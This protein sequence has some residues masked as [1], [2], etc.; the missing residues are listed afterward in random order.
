LP[1]AIF[2]ILTV[3]AA[4]F[5]KP[6]PAAGRLAFMALLAVSPGAIEY[7]Q[8]AR[9]YSLL[10]L[11][12]TVVTSACLGFVG[13]PMNDRAAV[14]SIVALAVAGILGSYTH[15]FGFL[16]AVGAAMVAAAGSAAPSMRA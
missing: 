8:E 6:L 3:A 15:Y 2:G 4:A 13:N 16:L 9:S 5:V 10:L 7:A 14:W 11:F 12:S 1:S